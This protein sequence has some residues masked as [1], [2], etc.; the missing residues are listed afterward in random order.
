MNAST[1]LFES[2]RLLFR[3]LSVADAE[4]FYTLNQDPEVIKYTGDQAFANIEAAYDFLSSYD[5]YQKYGYGRWAVIHKEQAN[6]LGWCGLRY[7]SVHDEVD[8][9]YRFYKQFWNKGYATEAAQACLHY[10][11]HDLGIQ[12]IV[13][14]A[15]KDNIASIRV[16]EK[17]GMVF[18]K[19]IVMEGRKGVQYGKSA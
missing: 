16:L 15:L 11:F 8:L 9:G 13:G 6:I 17:A 1:F 2:E 18:Q 19:E 7:S 12:Y 3:E 10:G 5:T 14:R 4:F